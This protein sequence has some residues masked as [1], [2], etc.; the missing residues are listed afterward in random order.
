MVYDPVMHDP[1]VYDPMMHDPMVHDPMMPDPVMP[2]PV[3]YDTVVY[4]LMMHD[5]GVGVLQ[6]CPD[7]Q[8]CRGREGRQKSPTHVFS[9]TLKRR[10]LVEMT[11]S[12]WRHFSAFA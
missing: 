10:E 11:G 7:Y 12:R 5:R 9:S 3:V 6:W 4:D 1:V 8:N 2:D